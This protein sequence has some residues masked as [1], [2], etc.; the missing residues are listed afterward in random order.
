MAGATPDR[1]TCVA[2]PEPGRPL[3]GADRFT[4]TL[5]FPDRSLA[6]ILYGTSTAGVAK[7]H[8]EAQA[9]NRAALLDDYR[10]LTTYVGRR[11]KTT[12]ARGRDKGHAAQ[13]EHLRALLE[14]RAEP[15]PVSYLD[16]M[17]AT[18]AALESAQGTNPSAGS[19]GWESGSPR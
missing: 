16:T 14:G 12:R 9:G 5:E 10:S 18:L 2:A 11:R 7:E 15:E 4:I 1:V 6:T 3:A 8:I 19:P 17:E 13:F